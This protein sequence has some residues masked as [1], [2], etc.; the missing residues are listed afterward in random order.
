MTTNVETLV[1][2]SLTLGVDVAEDLA[3]AVKF[4]SAAD[5][6]TPV[7]MSGITF[8]LSVGAVAS[9]SATASGVG[10]ANSL[11][12]FLPVASRVSWLPGVYPL[13]LIASDGTA[14]KALFGSP[15]SLS[16]FSGA[17]GVPR[18][19]SIGQKQSWMT[20][21]VSILPSISGG[22]GGGG[23]GLYIGTD[24]NIGSVS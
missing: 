18:L 8:T 20:L 14:T 23:G 1:P 7:S 16:L 15:S 13:S 3:F 17:A 11:T 2:Y 19:V 10:A 9:Y 12:I 22:G 24:I 6:V 4:V 21:M 5:G